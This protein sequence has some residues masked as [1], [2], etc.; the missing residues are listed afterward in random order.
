M[1]VCKCINSN[2]HEGLRQLLPLHDLNGE[3]PRQVHPQP[4]KSGLLA[5]KSHTENMQIQDAGRQACAY[6]PTRQEELNGAKQRY[7]SPLTWVF[8]DFE[9]S[10]LLLMD[11]AVSLALLAVR[12]VECLHAA[13]SGSSKY[14]QPYVIVMMN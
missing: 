13:T 5:T 9:L 11:F 6:F 4:Y 8:L 7:A 1:H 12:P 2:Q 3:Q 10:L 14:K